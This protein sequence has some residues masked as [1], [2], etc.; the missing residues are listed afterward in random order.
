MLSLTPKIEYTCRRTRNVFLFT[1]F[2]LIYLEYYLRTSNFFDG[3][4]RE[5]I[6]LLK[7]QKLA[8]QYRLC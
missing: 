8:L 6:A 3:T 5:Y 1:I 7:I 2:S 4:N